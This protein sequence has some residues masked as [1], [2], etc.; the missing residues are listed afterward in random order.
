MCRCFLRNCPPAVLTVEEQQQLERNQCVL[1]MQQT[2]L[3]GN[4]QR[5]NYYAFSAAYVIVF[6]IGLLG[7]AT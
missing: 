7:T 6:V 4:Q 3:Q 5:G 2:A 1:A